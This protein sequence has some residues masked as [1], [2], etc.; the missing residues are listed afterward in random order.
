MIVKLGLKLDIVQYW[1][2]FNIAIQKTN[3]ITLLKIY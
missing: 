1:Q 3:G 2:N